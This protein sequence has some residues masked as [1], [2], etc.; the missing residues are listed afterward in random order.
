MRNVNSI[1]GL[2]EAG[3]RNLN[4]QVLNMRSTQSPE[5]LANGLYDIASSGFQGADGLKVL[6]DAAMSATAGMT[7]TAT[8]A[9]VIT[10]A[11]NAYQL[12]AKD[13]GKVTD[14]LFQT[15]NKGVINFEQ[16]AQGLGN[17]MAPAAASDVSLGELG[18]AIATLT[19][20]GT[21]A[22][23][24]MTNLQNVINKILAP[25]ADLEKYLKKAG[26]ASGFAFLKA[27]GL[28]GSM[29]I[30]EKS[31]GG[32]VAELRK[33]FPDVQAF[34]GVLGLTGRN[35]AKFSENLRDIADAT[36]VAGAA[37]K[38]YQ[39]QMKSPLNQY[40]V[41]KN[42]VKSKVIG[43]VTN[44]IL[45]TLTPIITAFGKLFDA[46]V[47]VVN[48]LSILAGKLASFSTTDLGTKLIGISAAFIGLKMAMA[49]VGGFVAMALTSLRNL[50]IEYSST[51]TALA[52]PIRLT[53]A[54]TFAAITPVTPV[55]GAGGAAAASDGAA[56]RAAA[57]A[58]RTAQANLTSSAAAMQATFATNRYSDAQIK[59]IFTQRIA[60]GEAIRAARGNVEVSQSSLLAAR[61]EE[62]RTEAQLRSVMA[63]TSRTQM[64]V[65]QAS[66][67]FEEATANS[68][69]AAAAVRT[70][71]ADLVAA[72]A[73]GVNATARARATLLLAEGNLATANAILLQNELALA[74]GRTAAA[75]AAA[76]AKIGTIKTG[77]MGVSQGLS[78][79]TMAMGT[80]IGTH[81]GLPLIVA[82]LALIGYELYT[83]FDQ[84][85]ETRR[86]L[87]KLAEAEQKLGAN[88]IEKR[89]AGIREEIR[90]ST[91]AQR[92]AR[93]AEGQTYAKIRRGAINPD[94]I[95]ELSGAAQVL[96]NQIKRSERS[97]ITTP[98]ETIAFERTRAAISENQQYL[99]D[100]EKRIN[101][102]RGGVEDKPVVKADMGDAGK[103]K[104]GASQK[105]QHVVIKPPKDGFNL[106]WLNEKIA[107]AEN[108]KSLTIKRTGATASPEVKAIDDKLQTLKEIK[109]VIQRDTQRISML[110]IISGLE[111]GKIGLELMAK[112]VKDLNDQLADLKIE[113]A[114][115]SPENTRWYEL[116]DAISTAESKLNIYQGSMAKWAQQ[117][118][119][120]SGLKYTKAMSGIQAQF[121][122]AD[123]AQMQRFGRMQQ[124]A[125]QVGGSYAAKIQ[126]QI[127]L[128]QSLGDIQRQ[129]AE[130]TLDFEKQINESR[131]AGASK[132]VIQNIELNKQMTLDK[133]T[134]EEHKVKLQFQIEI[135]KSSMEDAK[136]Q[137][138][139][140]TNLYPIKGTDYSEGYKRGIEAQSTALAL[141][142]PQGGDLYA[143]LRKTYA[144]PVGSLMSQQQTTAQAPLGGQN[145]T[146]M[147]NI[148]QQFQGTPLAAISAGAAPIMGDVA[149]GLN[150]TIKQ[151]GSMI[152]NVFGALPQA[153]A[154]FGKSMQNL[155]A[156]QAVAAGAAPQGNLN[157]VITL[158]EGVEAKVAGA[159][160]E[161]LN[162]AFQT[163]NR[164]GKLWG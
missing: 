93:V 159:A 35:A 49:P 12:K 92:A 17:I 28:A 7:T 83:I 117:Y 156:P 113:Q 73:A 20:N 97:L 38:T 130:T 46:V 151:L 40:E 71:E 148:L 103:D 95:N 153:I 157:I 21:P 144:T 67:L 64:T 11:L 106:D 80:F 160:P 161:N 3:L 66:A 152:Q 43:S 89:Y 85:N 94:D 158:P 147:A 78:N 86:A 101:T 23:E 119:E 131:M 149:G 65:A 115:L 33:F 61:A 13:S 62:I 5:L 99:S 91:P 42:A 50:A 45:P 2:T 163:I 48:M 55:G 139:D 133:L 57:A 87:E 150:D 84:A 44:N 141:G 109:D 60:A 9:K 124:I 68:A 29:N 10:G 19:A 140:F 98:K 37:N 104:K 31:V 75:A 142:S 114:K 135:N 100:I 1:T 32:N 16:L 107:Q 4:A 59:N 155:V 146:G 26:Y 108:Q 25:S 121:A 51:R 58:N 82:G 27:N 79:A 122:A 90:K 8:A 164:R 52:Q 143:A 72:R 30:L 162:V 6:E 24:S 47:P 145:N 128:E 88:H 22:A 127:T 69:A 81:L 120:L 34:A 134:N 54:G 36:K 112:G 76:A 63:G 102:L 116:A 56:I 15:V 111:T 132:Y 77:L 123:L 96:R 154:D 126:S 14:V 129:R 53:S 39:E 110:P 41:E 137:L 125:D 70:A 74:E 118:Q 105:S 138:M 136:Q 18:A